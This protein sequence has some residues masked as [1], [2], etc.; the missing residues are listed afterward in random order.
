MLEETDSMDRGFRTADEELCNSIE[1]LPNQQERAPKEQLS[2][3]PRGQSTRVQVSFEDVIAEPASTRSFD[4]VWICSYALF[5]L[6]KLAV[7]K[8]CTLLLAIPFSFII[9]IFFAVLSFVHIWLCMPMIKTFMMILP[10][11]EIIWR[12]MMDM[13]ISPLCQSIGRCCSATRFQLTQL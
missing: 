9:G 4:T 10:S 3:D 11:L 12:S 8:L 1:S 2:R 7:Y 6:S 13:F 5:E